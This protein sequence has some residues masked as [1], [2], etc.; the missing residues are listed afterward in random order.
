MNAGTLLQAP[1]LNQAQSESSPILPA[2][3]HLGLGDV[4]FRPASWSLLGRSGAV[5]SHSA[6]TLVKGSGKEEGK[7]WAESGV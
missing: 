3:C 4:G 2:P 6:A 5:G 1:A 7:I